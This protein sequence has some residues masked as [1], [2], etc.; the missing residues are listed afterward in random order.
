MTELQN[1]GGCKGPLEVFLFSL[2]EEK[3]KKE[4][5]ESTTEALQITEKKKKRQQD[6]KGNRW[7]STG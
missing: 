7:A 1:S 3:K 4:N 5:T 2:Q 6:T